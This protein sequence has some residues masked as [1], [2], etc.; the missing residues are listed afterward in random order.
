MAQAKVPIFAS[1]GLVLLYLAREPASTMRE[2][3]LAFG[4]SE[5]RIAVIIKD[6][7]DAEILTMTKAG[8]RNVYSINM[9]ATGLHPSLPELSLGD[10]IRATGTASQKPSTPERRA[11]SDLMP[12]FF[13][14]LAA[15]D[16]EFMASLLPALVPLLG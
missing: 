3:S 14:P 7:I 13:L 16:S 5:R 10:L 1:Q 12:A 11:T 15:T 4:L 6:L 9:A 8:K 2:M